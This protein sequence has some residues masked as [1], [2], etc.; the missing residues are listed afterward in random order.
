[1]SIKITCSWCNASYDLKDDLAGKKW[2]C[3]NCWNIIEIPINN[4]NETTTE[5][6]K[7]EPNN[8]NNWIFS[9]NIYWIK[10]K[11][12]AINEKYFIK[13]KDNNDLLFSI[14][15]AHSMRWLLSVIA[16][17][18]IFIFFMY[19]SS[20]FG[21]TD[22]IYLF[23]I[24]IILWFILWLF[25]SLYI[26][27]ERHIKFFKNDLDVNWEPEFEIKEDSKYQFINKT[28]TMLNKEKEIICKYKKNVFTNILRKKWHME[29]D[30]KHL[31]IKEDS[32]ILWLL[33][34]FMPFW[35]LIRTNF[36]FTD[37]NSW[38]NLWIFKRKFELFDNYVLD[39][40]NDNTYRVPRQLAIWMA[41]LLDT[42][43][44]R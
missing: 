22:S 15:K 26:F 39:L 4:E 29:F 11:K 13:D 3:P 33:R 30:W 1:M 2:K 37:A 10:Q 32:I 16:F 34:R 8:S 31:E 5:E 17:L 6:I 18:L 23:L 40:S 21:W 27:P 12:I 20:I 38:D 44:G 42:W 25:I 19:L 24:F 7:T 41:I 36:I 9:H 28:Y 35:Q 14:R 43:E